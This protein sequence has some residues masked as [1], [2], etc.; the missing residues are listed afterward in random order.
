MSVY[1]LNISKTQILTFNYKSNKDI[2][3]NYNLNW[4][5]KS[6]KYG[7]VIITQEFDRIHETNYKPIN[8]RIQRDVAKWST[9]VM[10]FSSRV[11]VVKMNLL[12]RLLYLFLHSQLEY[13]TYNSQRGT[14]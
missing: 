10:D 3:K 8:K 1:K 11:E 12:P 7:G 5:A 13:W 2:R 6:I 4:N 14:S 9:L